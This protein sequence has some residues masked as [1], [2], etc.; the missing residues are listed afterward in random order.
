MPNPMPSD[1]D[2]QFKS[3]YIKTKDAAGHDVWTYDKATDLK[4]QADI[5]ESQRV[6]TEN[7]RKEFN[8]STLNKG[9]LFGQRMH[10][11]ALGLDA[12]ERIRPDLAGIQDA[13]AKEGQSYNMQKAALE[14]VKAR[15]AG[16]GP[17]VAGAQQVQGQDQLL[18]SAAGG[19]GANLRGALMS[20]AMQQVANQTG[21]ARGQETEHAQAG[22]GQG[23]QALRA[24]S[25]GV[26]NL[27]L[28]NRNAAEDISF[29]NQSQDLQR[30][31][32]Y[33][34]LALGGFNQSLQAHR[35]AQAM[36][37][38]ESWKQYQNQQMMQGAMLSAAGTGMTS[39]ANFGQGMSKMYEPQQQ[40]RNWSNYAPGTEDWY[41]TGGRM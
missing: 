27:A 29:G 1:K 35:A 22:W 23:G 34:Q 15:A 7:A 18:R 31:L 14:A 8:K 19:N 3:G 30:N 39:M 40:Q 5:A 12:P 33:E 10:A 28:T 21:S 11:H 36:Q 37:D 38:E 13:A 41:N 6:A 20:G 32:S 4:Q 24:G 25:Q 17:S 9:F 16:Q 26:Q 2:Y